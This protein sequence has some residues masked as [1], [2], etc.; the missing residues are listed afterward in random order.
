MIGL[1][2]AAAV[3]VVLLAVAAVVVVAVVDD[4][5][6][7]R[8]C[9][10]QR[11]VDEA[12]VRATPWLRAEELPG[13]GAYLEIHWQA[14]AL[15]DPCSRV[16]GPVDWTYQ[17][18]IRLRPEDARTLAAS[19]AWQPITAMASSASPGLPIWPALA[20][21]VDADVHWSRSDVYD[22]LPPQSRWR[23]VSFDADRA[24]VLFSL[25]DH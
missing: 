14:H 11:R 22:M 13:F 16:P 18:V 19:Y 12:K 17:G 25:N 15:G 20:P 8:S 21:F 4:G 1:A 23:R 9:V 5:R 2:A 3:A 6:S 24:L 7:S 10:E